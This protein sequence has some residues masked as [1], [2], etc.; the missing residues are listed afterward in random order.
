VRKITGIEN[1][2]VSFATG[3]A[4]QIADGTPAMI[5]DDLVID[6][7][8]FGAVPNGVTDSTTA[9]QAAVNAS[10][11]GTLRFRS[12]TYIVSTAISLPS[13]ITVDG[14]YA[15]LKVADGSVINLFSAVSKSGVFIRNLVLD[16][17]KAAI[18]G[19]S[20]GIVLVSCSDVV[21]ENCNVHDFT[22][23][24][25]VAATALTRARIT[26]CSVIDCGEAGASSKHGIFLYG[27][28][29]DAIIDGNYVEGASEEGILVS[30]NGVADVA[31]VNILNNVVK[32][33]GGIGIYL[34]G[35]AAHYA[36]NC[37]MVGNTGTGCVDQV[38]LAYG[39][40]CTV[41]GNVGNDGT[42]DGVALQFCKDCTVTGNT[43]N[44]NGV[45][46]INIQDSTRITVTGN[47]AFSNNNDNIAGIPGI[48]L[49]GATYCTVV[50]NTASETGGGHQK[51][52]IAEA[53]AVGAPNYNLI[54]GNRCDGNETSA[55]L[56]AGANSHLVDFTDGG[57]EEGSIAY[58]ATSTIVGWSA[59]TG[60]QISYKK[61]GRMV[62]VWYA[63]AGTSDNVATSFTLPYAAAAI[64]GY[65]AW[66]HR[67]RDNGVPLVGGN[68]ILNGG[69]STVNCYTTDASAGWTAAGDKVIAGQVVYMATS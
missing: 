63:I 56:I 32:D 10:S 22:N 45:R 16:G 11:G 62:W 60:K 67:S 48:S 19:D 1:R 37:V 15:T 47:T 40:G 17:N 58:E 61:I 46:G 14:Y 26:G 54:E 55:Y 25:I 65:I 3:L 28:I 34:A 33:C 42:V 7:E 13:A 44:D 36:T 8:W 35:D 30:S 18:A 49:Y 57:F 69:S 9:I 27:A 2:T 53:T 23:V 12:G 68:A 41:S 43:A 51:Y 5:I 66:K 64:P 31:R 20:S 21:I 52:G 29:T 6:P 50:G 24:G 4:Y 39:D 59:Y 38:E